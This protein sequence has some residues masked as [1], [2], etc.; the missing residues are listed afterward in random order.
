ML[1]ISLLGLSAEVLAGLGQAAPNEGANT[2][3]TYGE[4]DW[5]YHIWTNFFAQVTYVKGA[6]FGAEPYF[7]FVYA[8]SS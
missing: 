5:G 6:S 4:I 1:L 2:Q 7:R 8:G 3:A